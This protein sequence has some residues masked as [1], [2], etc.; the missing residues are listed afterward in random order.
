MI[1]PVVIGSIELKKPEVPKLGELTAKKTNL[2][3]NL[4]N[5]DQSLRHNSNVCTCTCSCA[6]CSRI[7][8]VTVS[9][10]GSPDDSLNPGSP[11]IPQTPLSPSVMN[12]DTAPAIMITSITPEG[13]EE[14][15]K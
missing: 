6:H 8:I 3:L 12:F 2:T 4:N 7:K 13:V 14:E 11:D 15:A 1:I 10:L 5:T 9:D